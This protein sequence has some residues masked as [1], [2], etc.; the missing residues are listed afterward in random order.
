MKRKYRK[1]RKQW[2]AKRYFERLKYGISVFLIVLLLPYIVTIFVNGSN[3]HKE[4]FPEDLYGM[5]LLAT[6]ISMESELEAIKAQAVLVRTSLYKKV[7]EEGVD[8]LKNTDYITAS[9]METIWGRKYRSYYKRLKEAW[10]A[11]D[12]KVLLYE[13]KPALTPYFQLGSGKTRD[14]KEALQRDDLP[15][16]KS[17]ECPKDA[18]AKA[19][20]TIVEAQIDNCSIV[21]T[22]SAGYVLTVKEGE[23]LM[24]GEQFQKKYELPSAAFSFEEKEGA[25]KKIIVKG[26][27]HGLGLSQYTARQMAKEGKTYEEILEFF[28]EGTTLE[29]VAEIFPKTE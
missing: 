10:E 13:E 29:E 5:G 17:V 2:R 14:A 22:D 9:E 8:A 15:Y 6:E 28:Y 12:R 3:I 18:E 25:K 19:Q 26:V 4:Q 1:S 11:T 23:K 27:G 16:L 20:I 7:L 24:S 21:K